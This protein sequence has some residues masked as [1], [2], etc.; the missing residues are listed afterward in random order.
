M[1]TLNLQ[2]KFK[3]TTTMI[4]REL[5]ITLKVGLDVLKHSKR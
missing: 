3:Y 5:K 2:N 1:S 4:Q